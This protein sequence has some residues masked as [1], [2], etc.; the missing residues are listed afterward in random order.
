MTVSLH[1]P[2]V[3]Q[4]FDQRYQVLERIGEGGMG[5]VYKARQLAMD[6]MVALKVI[7]P[8]Q[9]TDEVVQRFNREMKTSSRLAHPNIVRVYDWGKTP[10]GAFFLA[11]ELLLGESLRAR[12]SRGPLSLET[13]CH[14]ALQML[15][16][17]AGAH[18]EQIVHRDLKPEN[19]MLCTIAGEPDQVRI[20][21]FGIATFAPGSEEPSAR[22]TATG[23]LVGTPSYISPE[24]I[25]GETVDGRSDLY[26]FGV[27]L[28]EML[29]GRLPFEDAQRPLRVLQMHMTETPK[30]P[31]TVAPEAQIPAW[32]DD[33]VLR[34]LSKYPEDRPASANAALGELL[35]HT[36]ATDGLSIPP[37]VSLAP[38]GAGRR[39]AT[40]A[41]ALERP[42]S[43]VGSG[44]QD[45]QARTIAVVVLVVGVLFG[46]G[47]MAFGLLMK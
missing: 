41:P 2:L 11:M 32:A 7:L 39:T 35:A 5:A 18:A 37:G 26:S 31:S 24:Q 25:G 19:I 43:V 8:G 34:L 14:I 42:K 1:D 21:D 29:T 30:A 44:E 6:R 33:F 17:L 38:A 3:G 23:I 12:L 16:A 40:P 47:G 22:I 10:D 13:A 9:Q 45:R 46:I 15:K 36:I 20:L 28:Y 27:L 4:L